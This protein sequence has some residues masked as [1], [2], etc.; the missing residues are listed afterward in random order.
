MKVKRNWVVTTR[1]LYN[2]SANTNFISKTEALQQKTEEANSL[3]EKITTMELTLN[4]GNDEKGQ[5]EVT[6]I[7]T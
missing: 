4:S 6:E 7:C 5:L 3:K 1:T 2:F